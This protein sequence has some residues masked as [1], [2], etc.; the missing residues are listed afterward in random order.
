[1][2]APCV[3]CDLANDQK[4]IL[5]CEHFGLVWDIAPMRD[6]HLLII[7][8]AH[9]ES[10]DELSGTEIAELMQLQRK[11]LR[12]IKAVAS[13]FDVTFILNNGILSDE[14]THFH[15]HVVP[16]QPHDGFWEGQA[17]T[18]IFPKAAFLR[19]LTK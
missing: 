14:G 16:R 10:L 12:S 7:T 5:S 2:S 4:F 11:V 9:R 3:F 6:G 13:D 8:K 15:V 18:T 17:S 19:E 1:M